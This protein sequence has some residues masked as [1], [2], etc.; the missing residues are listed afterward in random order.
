MEIAE[1]IADCRV[2]KLIL[3]PVVENAIYHGMGD[4]KG[5]IAIA[6]R[7][8]YDRVVFEVRNGGY[9][10]TDE[11]IRRMRSAMEGERNGAGVGLRNVYR[12]LKLYYG[13]EADVE[14]E[15][16]PDESTSIRL[17]I[18]ATTPNR[19]EEET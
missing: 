14:I 15:S 5:W 2:M 6:G 8:E 1:E 9:G 13:E 11:Q 10:L 3:Q 7:R 16:V 17:I 4:E 18:P 12:R 19:S